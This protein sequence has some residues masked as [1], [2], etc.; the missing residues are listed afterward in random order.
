MS[1]Q[2]IPTPD[3]GKTWIDERGRPTTHM[4]FFLRGVFRRLGGTFDKVSGANDTADAAAPGTAEIVAGAGL[5]AG[6]QIGGNAA[7]ALYKYV[8]PVAGL[9]TDNQTGDHA[10]ATD[11]R[12]SGEGGGAGTGCEVVWTSAG[13]NL[14]RVNGIATVVTA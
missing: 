4:Q 7:I 8:G 5:T 2:K 11:G 10:F 3:F 6:G 14:W 9:P 13:I 1:D 12:N